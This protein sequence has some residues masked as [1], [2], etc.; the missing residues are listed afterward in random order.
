MMRFIR[1]GLNGQGISRVVSFRKKVCAQNKL[2]L[3]VYDKDLNLEQKKSI[4]LVIEG[5]KENSSIADLLKCFYHGSYM[6][7]FKRN[8]ALIY[9]VLYTKKRR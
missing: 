6:Q 9:S 3:D 4:R 8:L 7:G 1:L 2:L 5:L